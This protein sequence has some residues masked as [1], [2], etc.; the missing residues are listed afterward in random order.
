MISQCEHSCIDSFPNPFDI[1]AAIDLKIYMWTH[2]NELQITF[3]FEFSLPI[4]KCIMSPKRRTLQGCGLFRFLLLVSFSAT[5]DLYMYTGTYIHRLQVKFVL[6]LN[7]L[8]MWPLAWF[9]LKFQ[10]FDLTKNFWMV[11]DK[12]VMFVLLD[13]SFRFKVIDLLY[14]SLLSLEA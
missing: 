6:V 12:T 10:N 5:I 11:K 3:E 8:T 7:L 14:C 9:W 2:I 13:L 4:S 1:P